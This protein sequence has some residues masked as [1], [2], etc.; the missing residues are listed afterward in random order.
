MR[1]RELRVNRECVYGI[2]VRVEV[3]QRVMQR[4]DILGSACIS[5]NGV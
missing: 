2:S 3:R 5:V 1:E 4:R